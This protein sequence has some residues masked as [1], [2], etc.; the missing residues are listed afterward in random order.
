M[1]RDT[2][3]PLRQNR[4]E[5]VDHTGVVWCPTVEHGTWL[6]RRDGMVHWTGN[7]GM[8]GSSTGLRSAGYDIKLAANHWQR[9]IE[10]HSANHPD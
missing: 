7:C 2:A 10:T 9:A 8:G 5:W 1:G 4:V 6:C 3:K